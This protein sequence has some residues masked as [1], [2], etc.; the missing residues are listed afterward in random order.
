[1]QVYRNIVNEEL[2]LGAKSRLTLGNDHFRSRAVV[3]VGH[4]C[5]FQPHSSTLSILVFFVPKLL[6]LSENR[7]SV[8]NE[9]LRFST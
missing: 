4:Q 6:I 9:N 3:D 1:M 5:H 8:S 2:W 7:K